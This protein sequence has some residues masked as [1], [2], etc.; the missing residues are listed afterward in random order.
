MVSNKSPITQYAKNII[1][2]NFT[3]VLDSVD[4]ESLDKEVADETNKTT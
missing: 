2:Q 3:K 4:V 1:K